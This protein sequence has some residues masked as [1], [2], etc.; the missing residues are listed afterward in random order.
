M[1]TL[2]VSATVGAAAPMPARVRVSGSRRNTWLSFLSARKQRHKSRMFYLSALLIVRNFR[3]N[4]QHTASAELT[5]TRPAESL[6]RVFET[7]A[8]GSKSTPKVVSIRTP[9]LILFL[10]PSHIFG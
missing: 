1:A 7:E 3:L 2:F 4:E 10:P 6:K 5:H 8:R 9:T